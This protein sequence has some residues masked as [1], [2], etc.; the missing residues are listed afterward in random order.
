MLAENP[1]LRNIFSIPAQ[2]TG[3]QPAALAGSVLAYAQ[4]IKDLAPLTPV[5]VR[6]AEKHAALGV[7]PEHYPVV[8]K[9]LLGAI[10]DVLGDA[11]TPP[12]QEAWYHAYWQLARIF[13][14]VEAGLYAGAAWKGW[15]DFEVR[16]VHNE[17]PTI[18]SFELVPTD[19][20][21]LPL[22]PYRPGQFLTV[23]VWVDEL[24]CY[25]NRHYSLSDAPAP[26]GDHYRVTIKR[27]AGM[28]DGVVSNIMHSLRPGDKVE[29]AFPAGSFVLPDPVPEHVVL[30]SAGVGITPNLAM[31]NQLTTGPASQWPHITWVQGVR[32]EPEHV[33][34]THV[35]DLVRKGDGKLDAHVFYSQG[36]PAHG[37]KAGRIAVDQIKAE[38][39]LA[40]KDAVYFVCGPGS[41]MN[42]VR[43]GLEA[44]GVPGDKINVEAFHA[45]DA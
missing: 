44:A 32:A 43:A 14:D 24:Q 38:L 12:L 25:Q 17:S 33:F 11:F 13:I 29:A 28:P 31:L 15:A 2:K 42:D 37:A 34:R 5:V 19:K 18:T 22:K 3:A 6:I 41:F 10:G 45:G 9:N 8:G 4:N 20:S 21:M 30:L 16:A 35:A 36:E 40:D 7:K 26:E 27:E 39:P 23:R 1:E